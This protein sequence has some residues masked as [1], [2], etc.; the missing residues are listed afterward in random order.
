MQDTSPSA[1]SRFLRL[2]AVEPPARGGTVRDRDDD[3]VPASAD[4]E[5]RF[6]QRDE[7]FFWTWQYPGQW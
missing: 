4:P 6:G 5:R 1:V 2:F 3:R 7:A